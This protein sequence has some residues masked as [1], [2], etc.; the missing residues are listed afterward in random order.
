MCK[1]GSSPSSFWRPGLPRVRK[2]AATSARSVQ[3]LRREVSYVARATLG[4]RA[5]M[6]IQPEVVGLPF[7]PIEFAPVLDNPE[8]EVHRAYR[9]IGIIFVGESHVEEV[10]VLDGSN[11]RSS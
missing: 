5:I 7:L 4:R 11:A 3:M 10:E 9:A 1:A 2:K 6:A 8:D